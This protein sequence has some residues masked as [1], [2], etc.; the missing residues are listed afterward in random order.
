MKCLNLHG[1][2]I[3]TRSVEKEEAK[4]SKKSHEQEKTRIKK[5]K[6]VI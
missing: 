5:M 2:L 1:S 6:C 4:P 3:S